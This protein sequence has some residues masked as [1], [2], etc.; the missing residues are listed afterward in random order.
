MFMNGMALPLTVL[1][2]NAE[3]VALNETGWMA[4]YL[5]VGGNPYSHTH[6]FL[7]N[8]VST[9]DLDEALGGGNNSTCRAINSA[10]DV[11]GWFLPAGSSMQ[12][13]VIYSAG[14]IHDL[15]TLGGR[16]SDGFG[17]NDAGQVVGDSEISGGQERAVLWSD[18]SAFDLNGLVDTSIGTTLYSAND[19]NNFGQIVAVGNNNHSYLLTPVPEPAFT[20]LAVLGGLGFLWS[21]AKWRQPR[22]SEPGWPK[23]VK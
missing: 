13:A 17:M 19:I 23:M 7:Y 5:P 20:S 15:G 12:H 14:V 11:A 16:Y 2:Q 8:G 6:A 10:G 22:K 4:G 1:P 21:R 9:I 3:P 18:G